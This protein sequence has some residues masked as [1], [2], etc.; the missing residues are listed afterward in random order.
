MR[1]ILALGMAAVLGGTAHAQSLTPDDY[2]EIRNVARYYNL[3][4]DNSA[5]QDAGAVVLRSF[6]PDMTFTRDGGPNWYGAR[7]MADY[8]VKATSGTHHYDSNIVITPTPEGARVFSYTLVYTVPPAGSPI[9][10]S[11]GG[12]IYMLFEKTPEG[13]FIKERYNFTAGGEKGTVFPSFPGRPIAPVAA[14]KPA[15]A[16]SATR[17][18]SAADYVEIEQLYG[19]SNIALDSAAEDGRMF[20]RTFTPDGSM[21]IDGK[22]VTGHAAL[23]ALAAGQTGGPRRWLSNL[24][25]EPRGD[26]AIGWAYVLEMNGY[27]VHQERPAPTLAEGGL[28][29]DELVRTPDGWRF[30]TRIYTPG[31]TVPEGVPFPAVR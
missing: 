6:A 3:G 31:S 24:Y 28:Y 13:W 23:T 14:Q 30:K 15:K 27:D 17:A 10:V 29:R 16:G 12:P 9:K 22:T 25:I 21:Q 8:S 11:S 4:Y 1:P 18:L 19:W 26:G 7:Q 2:L 5:R 20:A